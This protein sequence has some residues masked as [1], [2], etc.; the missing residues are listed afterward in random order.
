MDDR[1]DRPES[2]SYAE[3]VE[4]GDESTDAGA[5]SDDQRS[6]DGDAAD[7]SPFSTLAARV[8][9]SR[10]S[11]GVDEQAA[12]RDEV[13][14]FFERESVSEVDADRLWAQVASDESAGGSDI[15]GRSVREISKRT[16][17]HQCE[18]FSDPPAVGCTN[19]GTSILELD[20]I[21]TF[22]VANCPIVLEE[23]S[24]EDR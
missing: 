15:Q 5:E 6:T 7:D 17:C 21:D 22:V 10:Q 3:D 19:E 4:E 1:D 18:H 16:Y 12:E 13:A 2:F 23:E 11:G 20:D 24:L 14:S 8:D 9:S